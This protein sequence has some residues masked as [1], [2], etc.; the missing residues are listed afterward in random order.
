[1]GGPWLSRGY[2]VCTY[3]VYYRDVLLRQEAGISAVHLVT[4][5]VVEGSRLNRRSWTKVT[6]GH[7]QMLC[8]TQHEQTAVAIQTLIGISK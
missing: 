5:G 7:P 6:Q 8:N 4:C 3:G 2:E 1:M